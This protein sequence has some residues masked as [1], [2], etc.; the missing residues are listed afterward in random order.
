[1]III[2]FMLQSHK[3]ETKHNY[4]DRAISYFLSK[5]IFECAVL[6]PITEKFLCNHFD[7]IKR[8]QCVSAAKPVP[9]K[10]ITS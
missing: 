8:Y 7:V 3:T 6:L 1:M 2:N 10:H 4:Y 5:P 9:N